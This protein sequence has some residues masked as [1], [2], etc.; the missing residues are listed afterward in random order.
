MSENST[1]KSVRM[2][3]IV[4]GVLLGIIV[5][6]VS[7]ICHRR[8]ARLFGRTPPG[9]WGLPLLGY[10]PFLDRRAPHK[11]LQALAKRYGSIYQLSMGSVRT[12]VLSDA[13]LVR[14]FLRHEELTARAPL[15]LT[16][17][18]MGGYGEYVRQRRRIET[19]DLRQQ[20]FSVVFFSFFFLCRHHWRW[21]GHLEIP[22]SP[23][24]RVA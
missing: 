1:D 17:G 14:E 5:I 10:L 18:I 20:L 6:I 2:E 9:P 24:Y 8:N 22:A 16:H 13:V 4:F 11:S 12:V 21:R 3:I 15:Y 7:L 23:A 19:N